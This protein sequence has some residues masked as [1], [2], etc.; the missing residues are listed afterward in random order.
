[1]NDER[2]NRIALPHCWMDSDTLMAS[3]RL[4]D[5][6]AQRTQPENG[7]S[8]VSTFSSSDV[9]L[10]K[11]RPTDSEIFYVASTI[12]HMRVSLIKRF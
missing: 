3:Q 4:D 9:T 6:S 2:C 10:R 12:Y 5:E 11:P 7:N 8:T 1:M